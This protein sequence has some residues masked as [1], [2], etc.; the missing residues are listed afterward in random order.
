MDRLLRR[1]GVIVLITIQVYLAAPASAGDIYSV[2]FSE[3][4]FPDTN[5][6]ADKFGALV[7]V[8]RTS[9]IGCP[10]VELGRFR[11]S[12]LPNP[13]WDYKNPRGEKTLW[14]AGSIQPLFEALQITAAGSALPFRLS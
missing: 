4:Y 3:G 10:G 7:I 6:A 13:Y 11:G 8:R 2:V 5:S 12:T 14:K 9:C 1:L